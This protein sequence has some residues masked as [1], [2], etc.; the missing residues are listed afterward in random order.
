MLLDALGSLG[1]SFW[2]KLDVLGGE[3]DSGGRVANLERVGL[4]REPGFD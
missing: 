2:V 4:E 3:D 1:D